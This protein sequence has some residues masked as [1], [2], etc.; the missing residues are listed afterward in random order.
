MIGLY[1]RVSTAEQAREGYSIDEQIQRL[2]LYAEA[3]GRKDYKVYTDGGYTGASME[4]PALNDL[5]KDIKAGKID[6]VIV[7]KLDR[8]SRSQ[9]DTLYLIEDAFLSNGVDFESM[10]ERFDTSTSFGRAMVGVLAVFAQLEREQIKERMAMGKEGR[11]KEGRWHGG[12]YAPIG[13]DYRGGEL[14]VNDLE[15]A[16]VREAFTMYASGA[17]IKQIEEQFARKGYSHAHGGYNHTTLKRLLENVL[18][19]GMVKHKGQVYEGIHE[20]IID[21]E[22]FEAVRL[23]RELEHD[24]ASGR[25][26]SATYLSGLVVCGKCGGRYACTAHAVGGKYRYYTCYNRRPVNKSMA[27]GPRCLNTNYRVDKLEQII[28][29]EIK[30]LALDPAEL[31]KRKDKS[32]ER[33]EKERALSA[34]LKKLQDKKSRLIDLYGSGLFDMDTVAAKVRE[35]EESERLIQAELAALMRADHKLDQDQAAK[36]ITSFGDILERG[37]YEEI[38]LVIQSL[39]DTITIDGEDIIIKWRF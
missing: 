18:Y 7:Y 5:L 10:S 14:I 1:T 31:H 32:G 38:R 27:T 4:R 9:K 30:K 20:Q 25:P 39:I 33:E 15:A 35:A 22:L 8:L 2:K 24:K 28:F 19:I 21:K 36:M 11:A 16:H 29:G 12:G 17:S 34:Q 13:Y 26:S 6:K 37:I 23:R 3:H